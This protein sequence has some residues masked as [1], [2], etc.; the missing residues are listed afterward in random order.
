MFYCAQ[1]VIVKSAKAVQRAPSPLT[2]G[3]LSPCRLGEMR[4]TRLLLLCYHNFYYFFLF[5]CDLATR[6]EITA[7]ASSIVISR[8]DDD[9]GNNDSRDHLNL[10]FRTLTTNNTGGSSHRDRHSLPTSCM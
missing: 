1:F 10:I 9:D 7:I 8:N 6:C 4:V 2:V 3:W 5:H